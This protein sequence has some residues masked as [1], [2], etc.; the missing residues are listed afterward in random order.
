MRAVTM[1]TLIFLAAGSSLAKP[2]LRDVPEI[3]DALFDVALANEIR[4]NCSNISARLIKGLGYLRS[5]Q[6]RAHA[7]G[8]S[9]AEIDAYRNSDAEKA[10]MRRRGDVWLAQRGVDQEKEADW[11]RVGRDEIR[12]SSR[13]GGLLREN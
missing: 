9:D 1:A 3:D 6:N 12:K 13:V 7:L 11:C 2:H 5:L 10:R 8:Y 4:K